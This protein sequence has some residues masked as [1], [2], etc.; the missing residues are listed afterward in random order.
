[1]KATLLREEPEQKPTEI[2]W[3]FGYK[4]LL[5]KRALTCLPGLFALQFLCSG[6][7]AFCVLFC[8]ICLLRC[9]LRDSSGEVIILNSSLKTGLFDLILVFSEVNYKYDVIF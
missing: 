1:M 2:V 8:G 3:D 5:L 4:W 7:F 9:S 6:P